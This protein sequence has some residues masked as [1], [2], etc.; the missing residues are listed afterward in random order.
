MSIVRWVWRN[1]TVAHVKDGLHITV[2][3]LVVVLLIH[4]IPL[5]DNSNATALNTQATAAQ[6]DALLKRSMALVSEATLTTKE[7]RQF[8]TEQRPILKQSSQQTLTLLQHAS[9]TIGKF[10]ADADALKD[11][12]VALK[13]DAD[14][15]TTSG[16]AA[17]DSIPPMVGQAKDTI[18]AVGDEATGKDM[19]A[20]LTNLNKTSW[21]VAQTS[22]HV[23]LT[24]MHVESMSV[25]I[26]AYIHRVTKPASF[27]K[28][29]AMTSLGVARDVKVVV[30]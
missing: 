20:I 4:A 30:H 19:Q 16:A 3:I 12:I 10:D 13:A 24:A 2:G 8:A 26:Q 22:E 28:Q 27:L 9:V 23:H 14:T 15:L 17:L 21:E 11:T 6:A 25:D 29:L 5:V 18:R 7:A 1:G